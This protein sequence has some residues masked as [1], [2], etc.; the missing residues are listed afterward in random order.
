M[1]ETAEIQPLST[2]ARI[3]HVLADT[4]DPVA[5]AAKLAVIGHLR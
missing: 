3:L 4:T 1:T 2:D 5:E